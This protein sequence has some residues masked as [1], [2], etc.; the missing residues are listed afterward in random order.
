MTTM[1]KRK[2][3]RYRSNSKNERKNS[4]R[5]PSQDSKRI[6]SGWIKGD[7]NQRC[8]TAWPRFILSKSHER[9]T[10]SVNVVRFSPLIKKS[11][12]NVV[13]EK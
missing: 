1:S 6:S 3:L 5:F 9:Q 8:L 2:R 4:W 11:W 13:R 10:R 12:D 7:R